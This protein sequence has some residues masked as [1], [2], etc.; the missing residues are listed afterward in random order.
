MAIPVRR[1]RVKNKLVMPFALV[2]SFLMLCGPMFAHHAGALYDSEHPVTL[3]GTVTKF[4]FINPHVQIHFQVKDE[5]GNVVKW[6]AG[7][8]P[9]QRMYRAGWN[10]KT[11]KPGDEITITCAPAKDGRKI[12]SVRR[13]VGPNGK[14]LTQGAE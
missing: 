13:V 5:N 11:L 10:M 8:A 9:P 6:V 3:E 7:S 2:G 4:A 1:F 14:V 12:C